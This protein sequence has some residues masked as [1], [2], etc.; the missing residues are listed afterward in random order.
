MKAR[1]GQNGCP[2]GHGA[3]IVVAGLGLVEG[4]AFAPVVAITDV[5][6]ALQA[7][8]DLTLINHPDG[9]DVLEPGHDFAEVWE[10][11][12]GSLLRVAGHQESRFIPQHKRAM[13]VE[14]VVEILSEVVFHN[15]A[16]G[17]ANIGG[18]EQVSQAADVCHKLSDQLINETALAELII[19]I[20][21]GFRIHTS[22]AQAISYV[23]RP[24]GR[25]DLVLVILAVKEI[26]IHPL[27]PALEKIPAG[28]GKLFVAQVAG[29]LFGCSQ[30]S[31]VPCAH[32]GVGAVVFDIHGIVLAALHH[33]VAVGIPATFNPAELHCLFH[34][35]PEVSE[36]G[37]IAGELPVAVHLHNA[38]HLSVGSGPSPLLC[39]LKRQP[40]TEAHQSIVPGGVCKLNLTHPFRQIA[41]EERYGL[42]VVPDV[43][44]GAVAGAFM[45]AAAFPAIETSVR[46]AEAGLCA[47]VGQIE[48]RGLLDHFGEFRVAEGADETY[49][50]LLQLRKLGRH[51][52]CHIPGIAVLSGV[53][54]ANPVCVAEP[55]SSRAVSFLFPGS[56]GIAVGKMPG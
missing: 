16:Q 22:Y 8:L 3:G 43:G 4:T 47:Q 29:H 44:T 27:F 10:G 45:V 26:G 34:L 28:L 25:L 46:R 9:R 19:G 39:T 48:Q 50:R 24:L 23:R 55:V 21:Q 2:T 7:V 11:N 49:G 14:M 1:Q 31:E 41:E 32:L 54:I 42:L 56:P 37:I 36:H 15:A 17:L 30:G 35:W 20:N 18:F 6:D 38:A 40:D 51:L 5:P 12:F 13:T 33:A 53:V 52:L